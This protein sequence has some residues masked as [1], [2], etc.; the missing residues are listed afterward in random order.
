MFEVEYL[1]KGSVKNNGVKADVVYSN[2]IALNTPPPPIDIA[3]SSH[4]TQQIAD[5][6]TKINLVGT[7][8]ANMYLQL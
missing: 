5:S 1:W 2:R 8:A 4:L 7:L 3:F 6:L